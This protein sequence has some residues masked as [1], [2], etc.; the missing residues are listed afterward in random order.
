MLRAEKRN[1]Q[2]ESIQ[3]EL[4]VLREGDCNSR[5]L[6]FRETPTKKSS[7]FSIFGELCHCWTKILKKRQNQGL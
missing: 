3:I 2:V 7:K 1:S 6:H 4:I 5:R